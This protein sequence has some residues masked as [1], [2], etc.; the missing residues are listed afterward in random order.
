MEPLPA[1]ALC[2]NEW[3]VSAW[4]M[5]GRL[6]W[7]RLYILVFRADVGIGGV[8]RRRPAVWPDWIMLF[9]Y[10]YLFIY[11]HIIDATLYLFFLKCYCL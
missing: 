6:W 11:V 5:M 8:Y 3:E 7:K 9:V 10:L 2:R 1:L 4:T